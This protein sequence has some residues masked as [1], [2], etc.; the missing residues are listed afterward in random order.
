MRCYSREKTINKTET[1]DDMNL[2]KCFGSL[3]MREK[4]M[5]TCLSLMGLLSAANAQPISDATLGAAIACAQLKGLSVPD[6]TF[7]ILKAESIANTAPNTVLIR[8]PLP[9]LVTV[10]VPSHCRADGE[11]K[12]RTGSD[13][14]PYAIGFSIV[15][16]DR[17]NGRFLFQGGGGTN[18]VIRPPWGPQATA[19]TPALA[20]GFAVISTDSGHL[21]APFDV[22]FLQ[23]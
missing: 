7:S 3:K 9:D 8:P 22:S 14:K 5:L 19:D 4:L 1:G 16:P 21:G 20:R 17:W 6:S 12:K 15:L 18:G 10:A 11:M 2:P 13:G 23:D